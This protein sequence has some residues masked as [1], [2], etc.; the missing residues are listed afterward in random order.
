[1]KI[2]LKAGYNSPRGSFGPGDIID[3]PNAEGAQLC[4]GGYAEPVKQEPAAAV[5]V[6]QQAA[7]VPKPRRK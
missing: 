7:V 6:P 1:M 2:K 3:V 4:A 5:V